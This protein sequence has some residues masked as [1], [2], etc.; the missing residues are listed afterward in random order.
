LQDE[1]IMK[2]HSTTLRIYSTLLNCAKFF[3]NSVSLWS[4]RWPQTHDPP[5]SASQVLGLQ[6]CTTRS[7][8]D[9]H[10]KWLR[11]YIL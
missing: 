11:Q 10:L 7:G 1:I 6:V 5:A 3:W 9:V 4:S 8:P 2:I